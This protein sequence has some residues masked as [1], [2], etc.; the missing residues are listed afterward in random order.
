MRKEPKWYQI[1]HPVLTDANT[2]TDSLFSSA[3][4]L[5]FQEENLLTESSDGKNDEETSAACRQRKIKIN[6]LTLEVKKEQ[7]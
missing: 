2:V 6:A 3:L 4:D 7:L 1:M 5:L